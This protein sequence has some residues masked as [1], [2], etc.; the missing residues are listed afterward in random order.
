MTR[1]LVIIPGV[2][3]T[4]VKREGT[5]AFLAALSL[6]HYCLDDQIPPYD[7]REIRKFLQHLPSQDLVVI[8]FSAGVVGAAGALHKTWLQRHNIHIEALLA[9]DGWL[10]PLFLSFPCYRLSHDGFTHQTSRPLGMGPHNFW[11]EP[12]VSHLGLWHDPEVTQGWAVSTKSKT[13]TTALNFIQYCL[14]THGLSI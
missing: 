2:Q 9:L 6:P 1:T 10:V 8:A 14:R 13:R 4:P 11:A 5:R 7:P 3:D 12:S